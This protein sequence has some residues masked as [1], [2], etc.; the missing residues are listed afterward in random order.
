MD[1]SDLLTVNKFAQGD[2]DLRR[3]C[4][5]AASEGST[6]AL[7]VLVEFGAD[8]EV[9]DR[10]KKTAEDEARSSGSVQ[11]LEYLVS[12]KSESKSG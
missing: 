2:Y 6:A 9:Q 1:L 11:A 7:K 10:W 3:A 8:L 12:L 4:H 5:I